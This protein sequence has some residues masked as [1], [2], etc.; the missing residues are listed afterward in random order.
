LLRGHVRQPQHEPHF[1]QRPGD[2]VENLAGG[3]D[4]GNRPAILILAMTR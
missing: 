4:G 3:N 2:A 1:Q